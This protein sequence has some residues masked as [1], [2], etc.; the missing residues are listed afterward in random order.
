MDFLI[1]TDFGDLNFQNFK[2]QNL[3]QIGL[4]YHKPNNVHSVY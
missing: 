1:I 3:Y 4:L 2:K